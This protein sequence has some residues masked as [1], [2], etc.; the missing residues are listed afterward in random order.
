MCDYSL[1]MYK[2][3]PAVAGESLV[4]H[5]FPMGS[6]G[7]ASSADTSCAVCISDGMLFVAGNLPPIISARYGVVDGAIATFI[8]LAS[9]LH[10]DGL[11]FDNGV[12]L[13]LQQLPSGITF[14][15]AEIPVISPASAELVE[16]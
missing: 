8:R 13:S 14:R 15:L 5:R 6:M 3:R 16:A 4:T 11:R 7:M 12:E 2:S 9:G 1:E 10:R